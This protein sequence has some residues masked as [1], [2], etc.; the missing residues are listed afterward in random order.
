MEDNIELIVKLPKGIYVASQ[1]LVVK[2]DDVV[3]IPLE[4]IA[5]G[6]PLQSYCG[7]WLKWAA[8]DERNLDMKQE[9]FINKPCISKGVCHEDKIKVLDKIR[10]EIKALTDGVEPEHIWNVDVFAIIDKYKVEIDK[11]ELWECLREIASGQYEDYCNLKYIIEH[12]TP[13]E[14]IEEIEKRRKANVRY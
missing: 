5:N 9:P 12:S 8:K 11:K 6:T 10:E 13:Q 2:P 1:M 3:Q 7:K 4:I 14:V